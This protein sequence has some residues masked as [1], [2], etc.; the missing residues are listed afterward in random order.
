MGYGDKVIFKAIYKRGGDVAVEALDI[1]FSGDFI[2]QGFCLMWQPALVWMHVLADLTMAI[3]FLF[4]SCT[5]M[6]LACRRSKNLLNKRVLY[7]LGMFTFL[8]GLTY[9]V[10]MAG[11]WTPV[12]Y[13]IGIVKIIAAAVSLATA[14]LILPLIPVFLKHFERPPH[15]RRATDL[16]V[17]D[18]PPSDHKGDRHK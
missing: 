16:L 18:D 12:Y 2:P 10:S 11:I 13:V 15:N 6:I 8:C 17:G 3:S 5:I 1:I 14:I 4:I 9:L 7:M